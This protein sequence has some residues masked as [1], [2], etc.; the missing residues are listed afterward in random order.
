MAFD[1]VYKK[2]AG[3]CFGKNPSVALKYLMELKIIS[4]GKVLELGCG[5][6]RD[7]I[8]LAEKSFEVVAMDV[9]KHAIAKL[10]K[11]KEKKKL[12]VQ[13]LVRDVTKHN[14][15]PNFFDM[16]VGT[17]ILDH[18]EASRILTVV[19]GIK[20]TLRQNGYVCLT[21][22]TTSDP[23]NDPSS[24]L[25]VSEYSQYVN[26]YFHPNELLGYFI[27]FRVIYYADSIELDDRHGRPHYHG[28]A[29]LIAKKEKLFDT[30]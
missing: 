9:S 18:L 21:V 12:S 8:F 11:I 10:E 3:L 26:H 2:S 17:T 30:R 16:V 20:K 25:T 4:G 24:E 7:S 23:G 19:E 14:Y 6:G 28:I 27:D 13:C 5:D 1:E 29:R 15:P 22:F